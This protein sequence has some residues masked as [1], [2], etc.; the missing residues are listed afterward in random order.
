[1]ADSNISWLSQMMVIWVGGRG[2]GG[3]GKGGRCMGVSDGTL[4]QCVGLEWR[5]EA[6]VWIAEWLTPTPPGYHR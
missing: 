5:R 6:E 4:V 2:G 1:M 3:D